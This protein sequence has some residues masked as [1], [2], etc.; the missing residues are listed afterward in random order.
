MVPRAISFLFSLFIN[1]M[2]KSILRYGS[3][4]VSSCTKVNLCGWGFT[5]LRQLKT[6]VWRY[7]FWCAPNVRFSST[8]NRIYT[9]TLTSTKCSVLFTDLTCRSCLYCACVLDAVPCEVLGNWEYHWLNIRSS[10]KPKVQS[11]VITS[12][13]NKFADKTLLYQYKH[14]NK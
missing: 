8:V 10:L 6:V 13:W 7:I 2:S 1:L 3:S 14:M 12:A 5:L 4:S 11:L 9:F